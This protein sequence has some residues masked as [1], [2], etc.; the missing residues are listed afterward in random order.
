MENNALL[1]VIHCTFQ[2]FFSSKTL[3]YL[4]FFRTH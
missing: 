4:A 2:F 1:Q 3:R